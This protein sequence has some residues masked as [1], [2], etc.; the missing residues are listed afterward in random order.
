MIKHREIGSSYHHK[1]MVQG[2]T[3]P[4]SWW[5]ATCRHWWRRRGDRRRFRQRF[6]L[7]SSSWQQ[8]AALFCVFSISVPLRDGNA[9]GTLYIV[10]FRSNRVE[11]R[12]NRR[13][14]TLELRTSTGGASY[15]AD[16]STWP[17]CLFVDLLT[18]DFSSL[19]ASRNLWTVASDLDLFWA[20]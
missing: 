6:P 12:E 19:D 18:A 20:P 3:T 7:Q 13:H 16:H 15:W 1:P 8:P 5:R 4:P 14:P 11:P 10:G 9:W 17:R 2:W